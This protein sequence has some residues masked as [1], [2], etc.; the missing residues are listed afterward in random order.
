MAYMPHSDLIQTTSSRITSAVRS[1]Y[2]RYPYPSYPLLAKPRWQEGWLTSCSFN[3]ALAGSL[4]GET[5]KAQKR[6]ILI[7]GCGEI[8]PA[9][10][11]A[12][13]PYNNQI[14]AV[15]LSSRS[16]KRAMFRCAS[17]L[18]RLRFRQANFVDLLEETK[19][20]YDHIDCYGVLHHLAN[21]IR[22]LSTLY[23]AMN[24]GATAR[25]MVY[26][27][28]ARSWIHEW[29]LVFKNLKLS[30]S[31]SDI[32][33]S[34]KILFAAG[35]LSP[36]LKSLLAQMGP[37]IFKNRTRFAD[38]FLHPREA[39]VSAEQWFAGLEKTGFRL[40]SL[41]DRYEECDDIPNPLWGISEDVIERRI[42]EGRFANNIEIL[43]QK[44]SGLKFSFPKQDTIKFTRFSTPPRAWL[45]TIETENISKRTM[46]SIWRMHHRYLGG[47]NGELNSVFLKNLPIPALQRLAR[48]GAILP[49]QLGIDALQTA[50]TPLSLKAGTQKSNK[51]V[52]YS[53][54]V[55][56]FIDSVCNDYSV[57]PRYKSVVSARMRRALLIDL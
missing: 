23:K 57:N 15:D 32:S 44:P 4:S 45:N 39:R 43:I 13:E 28:E 47:K 5:V 1:L 3:A 30:T 34:A 46:H 9:V 42:A 50:K 12:N 29:Q 16:I 8:L 2:E 10:I 52:L 49:Q 22:S 7:A 19:V 36:K 53:R 54:E 26:N 37:S 38:T 21:P 24:P 33:Q 18:F 6:K 20:T 31:P 35:E 55:E 14:D 48:L 41:F 17:E 56:E 40:V 51:S 27:S 25:I 11:C